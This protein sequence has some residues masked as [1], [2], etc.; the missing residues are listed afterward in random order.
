[1]AAIPVSTLESIIW[2]RIVDTDSANRAF[3]E[4]TLLRILNR[5]YCM[6]KGIVDDRPYDLSA[7]TAGTAFA[8]DVKSVVT[9]VGYIR[10][11][12]E[13]YPT[14]SGASVIPGGAALRRVEPWELWQMHTEESGNLDDTT[15]TAAQVFSCWRAGTATAADVGK[16]NVGIWR[17]S[18]TSTR[19][20]MLRVLKEPTALTNSDTPDLDDAGCYALADMTAAIGA[21]LIGR[22]EEEINDIKSSITDG[23]QGIVGRVET[24]LGLTKPR[25]QEQSA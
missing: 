6:L 9:S 17:K 21:R 13:V 12:L 15:L 18:G 14:S 24:E 22:S 5:N 7:T 23:W 1:M 2:D 16:W 4:T 19:T 8:T 20:Y 25:P 11:V 10:R 3:D